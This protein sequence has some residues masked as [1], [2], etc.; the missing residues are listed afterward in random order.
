MS[1]NKILIYKARSIRKKNS[2]LSFKEAY[3]IACI[4]HNYG[5][6]SQQ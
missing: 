5:L 6:K 2:K 4:K 1:N 3:R